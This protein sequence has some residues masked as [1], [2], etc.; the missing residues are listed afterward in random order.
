MMNKSK[1]NSKLATRTVTVWLPP[2]II[3]RLKMQAKR[4]NMSFENFAIYCI[5]KGLKT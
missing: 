2:D 4:L 1:K 3:S 5:S